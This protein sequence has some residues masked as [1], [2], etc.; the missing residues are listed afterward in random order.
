MFKRVSLGVALFAL[1]ACGHNVSVRT[2]TAPGFNIGGRNT[3]RLLPTPRRG[4][5]S[6]LT[7]DDPM[8]STSITNRAI[9]DDIIR[10]M[11]SRGYRGAG[12]GSADIDVAFYASAQQA[13]D[14]HTYDY[15]YTWRGWP[16][17]YTDVT[18]YERGTVIIDLVDPGTRQL[19]WRG[20]GVAHVSTDPNAFTNELGK[21]VDAIT[22][23]LPAPSSR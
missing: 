13:L 16:R 21:V 14:I 8:L 9:R 22:K 2:Q 6:A 1:A 19:L 20:Q 5:G 10:D 15:G 3:F 23:K 4:D 17:E 12:G 11:E 18:R 7:A